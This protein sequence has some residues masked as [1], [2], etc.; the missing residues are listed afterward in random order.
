MRKIL[1]STGT[2]V[3]RINNY[4]YIK[5]LE[6]LKEL[7]EEEYIYGGEFMM[8]PFYADKYETVAKEALNFLNFP[9]FHADKDIGSLLSESGQDK[10]DGKDAESTEK[11]EK[12]LKMFEMNCKF[13]SIMKSEKMVLHLWGGY[14]SDKYIDFNCS[15][16]ERM[17]S[18]SEEYGISLMIENVPSSTYD[19]FYN[20]LKAFSY[21]DKVKFIFDSRFA[22]VHKQ[23]DYASDSIIGKRIHHIHVSDF[24]GSER[25]FSSLRPIYHPGEGMVDFKLFKSNMDKINYDE[26]ITLESPVMK[27]GYLDIDKLK[28]SLKYIEK[29]L[30]QRKQNEQLY[31]T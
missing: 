17:Y 14:I 10:A 19:P 4:N 28:Q 7:K 23:Y 29:N 20:W 2:M 16:I 11:A 27:E 31:N 15:F 21:C 12:A 22:C 6:V 9:V 8:L 1:C 5:A 18:V 25:D 13:A 26:Y 24:I 3:G 30:V